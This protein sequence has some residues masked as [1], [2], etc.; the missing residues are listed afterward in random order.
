MFVAAAVVVGGAGVAAVVAWRH[1]S[2][3]A[4][5]G[6][7]QLKNTSDSHLL[8]QCKNEEQMDLVEKMVLNILDTYRQ[9]ANRDRFILPPSDDISLFINKINDCI[10][11]FEKI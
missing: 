6:E 3:A 2:G 11:F 1:R 4:H 9:K 7:I 10:D 5:A 8:Q